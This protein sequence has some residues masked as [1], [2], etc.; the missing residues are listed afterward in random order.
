M[1]NKSKHLK[2]SAIICI[3]FIFVV[4][5]LSDI[6]ETQHLFREIRKY[7]FADKTSHFLLLGSLSL[8]LNILLNFRLLKANK[9]KIFLGSLAA[10]ILI[11]VEEISQIFIPN[12][13]FDHM[14]LLASYLGIS[15]FDLLSRFILS[16]LKRIKF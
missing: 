15:A 14:D 11:T 5:A 2:V 12:R 8:T 3:A 10:F 1:M 7:P 13:T 4:I 16:G 6:R 9:F